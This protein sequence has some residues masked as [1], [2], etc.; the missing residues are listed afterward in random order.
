MIFNQA[1]SGSLA[2]NANQCLPPFPR[3]AA[4][5]TLALFYAAL[6]VVSVLG[7][8]LTLGLACREGKKINSTGVYLVHLALFDLLLTLTLPGK[9]I[10]YA[11]G[12]HWP[13]GDK[14]CRLA[15]FLVY[16]HTHGGIYILM[17]LS[18]DHYLAVVHARRCPPLHRAGQAKLVCAAIW[19]LALLQMAP[20]LLTPMAK[21]VTGEPTC[22]ENGSVQP[23]T[24]LPAPILVGCAVGFCTPVTVVFFCSV[25]VALQWCRAVGKDSLLHHRQAQP[26]RACLLSLVVLVAVLVR[27]NPYHLNLLQLVLSAARHLPTCAEQRAFALALQLMAALRSVNCGMDPVIYFFAAPRSKKRLLCILKLRASSSLSGPGKSFVQ[28]TKC[29]PALSREPDQTGHQLFWLNLGNH[30]ALGVG[31]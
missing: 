24:G 6:L 4:G 8:I 27:F 10:Y 13:L 25:K 3:L 9:I 11:L 7:N 17:C 29:Q 2:L 23:V 30:Q 5:M 18:V 1:D 22:T 28:N 31:S 12:F 14:L 16:M 19:C 15:A 21:P 26:R 20:L